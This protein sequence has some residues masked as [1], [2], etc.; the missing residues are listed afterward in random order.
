MICDHRL[1]IV[2][3]A[4][5]V[6]NCSSLIGQTPDTIPVVV[7]VIH[8]GTP[9]GS[10]DNPSDGNIQA[11]I[12]ELNDAYQKNGPFYGGVSVPIIFRLASRS[13]NCGSTN[14]INR[15]NGSS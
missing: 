9:V 5:I 7:H 8:T 12:A 10:P 4:A 13:P 14:G 11:M 2:F 6:L 1:K 15:V 3:I